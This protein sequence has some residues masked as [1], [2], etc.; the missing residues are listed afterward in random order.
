MTPDDIA[1]ASAQQLTRWIVRR[2]LSPVDIVA[3]MLER[4]QRSQPTLNAFI[5]VC[6]EQAMDAARAAEKAVMA[7]RPLGP[8]H[9]IPFAVKDTIDA[10]G[11]PTTFG[12]TALRDNVA[13]QDATAVARM[14]QAG[15]ILL[16]K[17]TTPEFA[18]SCFTEAA[19][20]GKTR[21]AWDLE[22]TSG[23]SSGGAAVAA[24]AGLC[25]L[26]IA[27]DSG[28]STR[29]PAAC[30][31]A[32]GLKPT[33]GT[34]P[35]DAAVE[36]MTALNTVTPMTRTAAE[37]ALMLGVM[38]GAHPMDMR[39]L[40]ATGPF[41]LAVSSP[42]RKVLAGVRIAWMPRFGSHPL[43]A[44]VQSLCIRSV[45]D[46]ESL[47][48][49]V[50]HIVDDLPEHESCWATLMGT[51]RLSRYGDFLQRHRE[52]LSAS[53]L[54]M[55]DNAPLRSA[56]DLQRALETRTAVFRTLQRWLQ[57]FDFIVT[58]ALTRTAL[59]IDQTLDGPVRIGDVRDAPLRAWM[60]YSL[61][62]NLSGHPAAALPC[63]R[64]SDGL[65]IA[66]QCIGRWGEDGALI[67]LASAL[68]DKRN[69]GGRAPVRPII[70]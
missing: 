34:V 49:R 18:H 24:A 39:S 7:G 14:R 13:A 52:Q 36:T 66:L 6:A 67:R 20:F 43:D 33:Q 56:L 57:T 4:I 11:L 30:N 61:A 32:F 15:A 47:G 25:T 60:P 46:L 2:E 28:G 16:G 44:E 48:A 70:H 54:S 51:A 10:A 41:D 3:V 38:A 55:I 37:S 59:S 26:G 23:G 19:L 12:S 69:P 45:G 5:S 21:N 65:P 42:D 64:H 17:T 50:E 22:R 1:F 62:P 53:L 58:P 31:G 63:G 35:D 68:E 40:R 9:G 8:L 29:T 27:T